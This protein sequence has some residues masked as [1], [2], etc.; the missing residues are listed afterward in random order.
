MKLIIIGSVASGTSCACKARRNDNN[1]EI[2]IYE[3]DKDISYSSCG[4]PYYIGEEYI[5]RDDLTP[6]DT[7]WFKEMFD[8]DIKTGNE[9]IDVDISNKKITVKNLLTGEV[10]YDNFDK[11]VFATGASSIIPPISGIKDSNNIFALKSVVDADK[12]KNFIKNNDVKKALIIGGSFIGLELLENIS[13][14]NVET[15]IIEL[16]P[17]LIPQFDEDI[18]V[19]LEDYLIKKNITVILNDRVT[20]ISNKG[21]SVHT[22]SGKTFETDIVIVSTGIKP[23]TELAK[24]IGVELGKSGA[25]K[26]NNKM[27]SS[28]PDIYAI[29]DCAESYSLLTGNQAYIPLGSTANKMGRIAGDVITGGDLTFRGILGSCI[30]KVFDMAVGK[31]GFSEKEALAMGY[32]VEVVYSIKNDKVE[33]LKESREVLIKGIADRKTEKLLGVEVLGEAGVDKR[34][35]VFATAIT[36]GAKVSDL[37]HLDLCYAPPFSTAK[38]PVMYTGMILDNALNR[39]RKLITVKELEKNRNN[40]LVIDVR[41]QQEFEEGYIEGAINIPLPNLKDELRKLNKNKTI[42]VYCNKG[43]TSNAAQNL[44]INL[45]FSGVLNLSGGYNNYKTIKKLYNT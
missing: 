22:S 8:I 42:V 11:L 15:T 5:K 19:Y 16:S 26:V 3:R 10:Y 38:D 4:L 2:V 13:K 23:N 27:E 30:V 21:G 35:D 32:D 44:L 18:T 25:I 7:N 39:G 43:V 33:Y 1:C 20:Q 29:G 36:F 41:S 34:L 6:M 28:I 40:F 17:H 14:M 45:G 37:F 9:L 24:K 12:I 31:T